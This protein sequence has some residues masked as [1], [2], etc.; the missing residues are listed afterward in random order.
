LRHELDLSNWQ[1]DADI[2]A[3]TF[4]S[5]KAKSAQEM[6]FDRPAHAVAPSGLKPLGTLK[7][8]PA[9]PAAAK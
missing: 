2:P 8:A 5:E 3:E 4:T 6:K 9:Q 7:A 1:I